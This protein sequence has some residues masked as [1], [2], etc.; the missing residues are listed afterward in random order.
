MH[1][2]AIQHLRRADP[3]L[4]PW[5]D[6]HG[7][8]RVPT[9]SPDPF[10]ALLETI[11]HQQLAGA[12]ANAIWARVLALFGAGGNDAVDIDPAAVLAMPDADLR[13]AGVSRGKA[14]AMKAVAA[15]A[16]AGRLPEPHRLRDMTDAQIAAALT[17][18]PGV[19][20]WTV[21]ML[22][23][24]TLRRPDILPVGDYGIRK[25]FQM[26]YRKRALPTPRQLTLAAER[27]RPYRTA[28]CLYLWRIA[29]APRATS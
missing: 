27:W 5:I 24:F 23:I 26:L 17:P 18:I 29:S 20:P 7:L 19:G 13:A 4:A 14:L 12:A 2:R 25:G 21:H 11:V 8:L 10:R 3:R 16:A 28:A 9:R 1:A 6:L 22:L 15:H